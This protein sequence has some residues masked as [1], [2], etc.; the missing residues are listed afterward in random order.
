LFFEKR[1][2]ETENSPT[3]DT[4]MI[5]PQITWLRLLLLLLLTNM[6]WT[7]GSWAKETDAKKESPPKAFTTKDVYIPVDELELLVKPL[8]KDELTS[9]ADAW[10]GLLKAK[11]E[12]VSAAEIAVKQKNREIEKAKEVKKEIEGARESLEQVKKAAQNTLTDTTGKAAEETVAAAKKAQQAAESVTKKIEEAKATAQDVAQ[13]ETVKK[14]LDATGVETPAKGQSLVS[15]EAV[16]AAEKAETVIAAVTEAAKQ[17]QDA[18]THGE[19]A[20]RA[21]MAEQTVSTAD[22]AQ[23]ALHDTHKAVKQEVEQSTTA[24]AQ[25]LA[26][27]DNLSKIDTQMKQTATANAEVKTKILAA[28]ADLRAERTALI[29]RLGV[30][31]NELNAKLGKSPEGKDNEVVV[32]YRLYIDSVGGL[33]VDVSDKEAAWATILGWVQSEEGGLRW[34]K[35][36]AVFVATVFAFWVLGLILGKLANKAFGIAR[37]S[38]VLLRNFV[39]HSV[40]RVTLFIGLI[41][42]LAALEVNIGPLLALIGAAGFVVA[43]ALQNTLSNFA[44][45]IM[46]MLYKPFDVGNFVNVAGVMGVVRSMN[47]VTTTITTADNQI[48]VVPNNSIWGNIIINITGSKE[49]RVDLVFGIGYGDDIGHAHQVLVDIV[50]AHPL[51]LKDP[52]PVI[53]V[54]ELAESSVNLICRPWA[55][56]D[57]YWEVYWSL[58]RMVKER[59]DAEGISIPFPQRDVHILQEPQPANS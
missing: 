1:C 51:V 43:F 30:V 57:D 31:L 49:R 36:I 21:R 12:E 6:I 14:A 18:G 44:S 17:T 5:R 41:F 2:N 9:E 48:M 38:S 59:F 32:P 13:D 10:L 35:N 24:M 29:D 42:G 23:Q 7:T 40:R 47:L 25:K 50:G 26:G 54:H 15:G 28:V 34:A 46:I 33:K 4:E 8:K 16:K 22:D 20:D 27:T 58:T 11:V 53:Q 45:G 19:D 55:K 3:G 56:T 37:N 52:E 39:V